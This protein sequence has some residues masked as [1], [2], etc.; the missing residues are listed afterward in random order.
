MTTDFPADLIR[1]A[2]ELFVPDDELLRH[3]T[4]EAAAAGLP[5]DWEI[6]PDVG[7][8]FQLLCRAINAK[9]VIECGTLAGH[10]ALWFTRGIPT[11]GHV[12]SIEIEPRYAEL[13]RKNLEYA[14]VSSKVTVV[15]GAVAE[16][17]AELA[18]EA[19][20][21]GQL[22]DVLFLDA[23]KPR[24]LEFMA[25]AERLLRPGGLL[26]ADNVLRSGTWNVLTGDQDN[27]RTE[28]IRQFN[29]SL[30][31]HPSFTSLILPMR[32]GMAVALYNPL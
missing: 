11:E 8:L 23:D 19:E 21:T 24:Y 20:A 1:Y 3:F 13:A 4:E 17:L 31:T 22:Y 5:Q 6:S 32:A 18:N 2:S 7:R 15:E 28:S 27:P 26:L 10:S 14:G 30:A 12:T 29:R 25:H 16:V 9:R